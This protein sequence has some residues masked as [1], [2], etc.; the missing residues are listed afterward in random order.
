MGAFVASSMEIAGYLGELVGYKAGLAL[1]RE[2]LAEHLSET[3]DIRDTVLVTENRQVRLRSEEFE[4][5][6]SGLLYRVGNIPTPRPLP[7]GLAVR[8]RFQ[9]DPV[10]SKVVDE[11][12]TR[13]LELLKG[14]V[15][16][17]KGTPLDPRRLLEA[18]ATEFGP[19]GFNIA[20]ALIDEF[21][22]QLHISPWAP[23]QSFDWDDTLQLRDLFVSESLETQYGKFFDQRFI[24][25]LARNPLRL[26][27]INWRRF[28]GL[29]GE[30]FYNAGFR[31][32]MGSGRG[33]GGVDIRV[34]APTDDFEKPPLILVQC[35]RQRE[36]VSQVII[37][38]LWADVL[39]EG[40][41]SGLIVTTSALTP[42]ADAVRKARGYSIDAAERRTVQEWI[43]QLRSPGSGTFLA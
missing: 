32:E 40:A 41:Q 31:V 13:S 43:E 36:K 37:K 29:A 6:V 15:N 18:V 14:E 27:E 2:E 10:H 42:S 26:D 35:K 22:L 16:T 28:E 1:T 23:R 17:P 38:A 19:P 20:T 9:D 25:F 8:R 4:E 11:I 39:D 33:D 24:D 34:W 7:P 3:P 12:L 5:A 21:A 30:F